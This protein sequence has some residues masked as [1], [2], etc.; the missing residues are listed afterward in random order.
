MSPVLPSPAQAPSL[1]LPPG[2]ALLQALHRREG[3]LAW[4][5]A[6]PPP[7][8]SI[9]HPDLIRAV[10][11]D[12]ARSFRRWGRGT[13]LLAQVHGHS[14]LTSEGSEWA[15]QRRLLQRCF[16][17]EATERC[18]QR[19]ATAAAAALEHWQVPSSAPLDFGHAVAALGMHAM[20]HALFGTAA[21]GEA[22]ALATA[23]ATLA[24]CIALQMNLPG[25]A[26]DT[27]PAA[28]RSARHAALDRLHRLVA[29]R[30]AE[31]L[32]APAGH[33]DLLALLMAA[34]DRADH[35]STQELHDHCIT[36][37]L[38]GQDSSASALG[39]WGWA[40]AA[41]PALAARAAQEVD[42]VLRGHPPG[43]AHVAQLPYLG[44]TLKEAMRLLPPTPNLLMRE[45]C[46]DVDLGSYHLARGTLL[47]ITPMLVHHDPRWFPDPGRFDPDRFAPGSGEQLPRGAWLPFGLG[48]R[49][50]I[51]GRLATLQ[52]T[53][54]AALLL[55]RFHFALPPGMPPPRPVPGVTLQAEPGLL[56]L[57]TPRP[58]AP[59]NPPHHDHAVA[60]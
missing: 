48:P 58:P 25:A 11:I 15:R 38:A 42:T 10:L 35:F 20:L 43:P 56:L 46:E 8:C 52:A 31:R 19:M 51:A 22:G 37:L 47:R 1:A 5:S 45:A 9:N 55:Q 44:R 59:S 57:L 4:T 49:A 26:G 41:H 3:D 53:L 21:P 39:W 54:V 40:M 24:R 36:L 13:E 6:G 18:A 30:L 34:D 23:V 32:Q 29:A 12:Q 27:L 2:L 14:V 7:C 50:C 28:L 17:A 16:G 33:D 60:R